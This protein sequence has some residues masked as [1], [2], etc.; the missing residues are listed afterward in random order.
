MTNS[1]V[2]YVVAP[3]AF[4][5]IPEN[6]RLRGHRSEDDS[7]ID[8]LITPT[9][10]EIDEARDQYDR[11]AKRL[12]RWQWWFVGMFTIYTTLAGVL[13]LKLTTGV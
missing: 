8:R 9:W 1:A 12:R 11:G 3:E 13:L 10:A 7:S 6:T 4:R 5:P 2:T